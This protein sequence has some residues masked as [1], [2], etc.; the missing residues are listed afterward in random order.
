VKSTD[1]EVK[2]VFKPIAIQSSSQNKL[3][4]LNLEG[5]MSYDRGFYKEAIK[6]YDDALGNTYNATDWN[7]KG[8]TLH[9]LKKY[10]ETG[11]LT[12]LSY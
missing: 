3:S 9:R 12:Q 11:Q 4:K 6:L 2:T 10:D 1:P 5:D 7:K 8:N